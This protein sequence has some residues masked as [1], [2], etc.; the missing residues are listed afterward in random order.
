MKHFQRTYFLFNFNFLIISCKVKVCM[1]V[2]GD[3]AHMIQSPCKENSYLLISFAKQHCITNTLKIPV[4]FLLTTRMILFLSQV[5]VGFLESA[6]LDPIAGTGFRT[7]AGPLSPVSLGAHSAHG[8]GSKDSKYLYQHMT[9]VTGIIL[10]SCRL[11]QATARPHSDRNTHFKRSR[12]HLLLPG[13][14]PRPEM[15]FNYLYDYLHIDMHR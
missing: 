1:K 12:H 9:P 11:Q 3:R 2:S 5:C 14:K 10:P 13:T 4:R 15:P 6:E 8:D 7:A